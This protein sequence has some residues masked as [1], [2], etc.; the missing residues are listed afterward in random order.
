MLVLIDVLGE[1]K[2]MSLYSYFDETSLNQL[3]VYSPISFSQCIKRK[4][5]FLIFE[6]STH[7]YDIYKYRLN[8]VLTA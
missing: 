3:T 1:I 2:N 4:I 6:N 8:L 5:L 7:H